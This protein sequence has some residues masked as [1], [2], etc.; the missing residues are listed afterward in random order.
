MQKGK[1]SVLIQSAQIDTENTQQ[2]LN[3]TNA[4]CSTA[5]C[6]EAERRQDRTG[7]GQNLGSTGHNFLAF[8]FSQDG[9]SQAPVT[10]EEQDP[11]LLEDFRN[12]SF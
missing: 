3:F 4:I 6:S 7:W 11:N 12:E 9:P 1:R 5:E 10:F 2:T 8:L